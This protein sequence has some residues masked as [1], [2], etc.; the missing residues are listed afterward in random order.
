METYIWWFMLGFVPCLGIW[1]GCEELISRREWGW[2][3]WKV[4]LYRKKEEEYYDRLAE[5]QEDG[6][7]MQYELSGEPDWEELKKEHLKRKP[8]R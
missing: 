3:P 8:S 7:E 5:W 2:W 6:W 1:V 4:P